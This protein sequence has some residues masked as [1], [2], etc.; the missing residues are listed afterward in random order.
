MAQRT[1]RRRGV[2]ESPGL[3]R[4][5]S[6]LSAVVTV[7]AL[8]FKVLPFQQACLP[9]GRYERRNIVTR[10]KTAWNRL[11]RSTRAAAGRF[12][13]ACVA[14]GEACWRFAVRRLR[15]PGP[16]VI[17]DVRRRQ[18]RGLRRE[19]AR[20]ERASSGCTIHVTVDG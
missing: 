6:A 18:A 3:V 5:L 12:L 8:L 15:R 14:A 4:A 2:R 11:L 9:A 17:V 7:A 20:A 16:T 19:V 1:T 13:S 10:R